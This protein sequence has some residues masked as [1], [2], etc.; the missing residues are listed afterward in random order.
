MWCSYHPWL[1]CDCPRISL[2]PLSQCL[3]RLTVITQ[4]QIFSSE[5]KVTDFSLC[6]MCHATARKKS[7]LFFYLSACRKNLS[8]LLPLLRSWTKRIVVSPKG[9]GPTS[10][11]LLSAIWLEHDWM[12]VHLSWHQW[13]FFLVTN[14][15]EAMALLSLT[16]L[17]FILTRQLNV[18][19]CWAKHW[20]L[21]LQQ[22]PQCKPCIVIYLP[23][24]PFP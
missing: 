2:I 13:V 18:P 21:C 12:R 16:A 19:L 14:K 8:I 17:T 3:V 6:G 7:L 20:L 9:C 4:K 15:F 10:D 5:N 23:S 11:P 1:S 24:G 22:F